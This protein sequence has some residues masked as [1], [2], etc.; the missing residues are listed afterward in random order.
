M[1]AIGSTL[2][3]KGNVISGYLYGLGGGFRVSQLMN[4]YKR[5]SLIWDLEITDMP[6]SDSLFSGLPQ[7]KKI[8]FK[9]R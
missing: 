5:E 1:D 2:W 6:V 7:R 3:V 8:S 9:N 4:F